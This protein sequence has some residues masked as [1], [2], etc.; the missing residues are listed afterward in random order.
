LAV[1]HKLRTITYR[2]LRLLI[3]SIMGGATDNPSAAFTLTPGTWSKPHEA[4][5]SAT[6]DDST[7]YPDA[8]PATHGS[9][10]DGKPR[11]AQCQ[12][13]R[14]ARQV[15]LDSFSPNAVDRRE[16]YLLFIARF[17]FWAQDSFVVL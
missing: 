14:Q 3:L 15:W 7:L 16:R 5:E 12:L 9:N 10:V 6:P 4:K 13:H 17:P 1:R 8:Q 11:T 2:V